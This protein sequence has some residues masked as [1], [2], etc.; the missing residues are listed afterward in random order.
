MVL[1]PKTEK[2]LFSWEAPMRPFQK[3]S[4]DFWSTV[5]SILFLVCLIL[6][7][8][9]EWFLIFALLALTFLYYA[10]T[11]TPA[12]KVSYKITSKGVW[13]SPEE[14]IDWQLLDR[15]WFSERWGHQLINFGTKMEFPQVISLVID[16]GKKREL[17]K[18]V[19]KYLPQSQP[20]ETFIDRFSRWLLTRVPLSS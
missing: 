2:T 20:P 5:L 9:G 11:S 15:F 8:T 7:F 4:R 14:R 3:K 19:E 16:P 6:F 13:F 10:L 17:V 1:M 12:K 18:V